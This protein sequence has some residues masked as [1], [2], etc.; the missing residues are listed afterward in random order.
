MFVEDTSVFDYIEGSPRGPA[1]WG[2]L[3][4]DWRVCNNGTMQSPIDLLDHRVQI[5]PQYITVRRV[6]RPAN[7]TL[8]NRGHDMMVSQKHII[9]NILHEITYE[10][11]VVDCLMSHSLFHKNK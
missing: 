3:R 5:L 11:I 4:P 9:S 2:V 1:Q 8:K 6:Y 7:A 10:Q